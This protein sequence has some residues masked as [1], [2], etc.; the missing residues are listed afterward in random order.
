[1]RMQP[2]GPLP[3]PAGGQVRLEPGGLHI[4]L[5]GLHQDLTTDS[6]FVLTLTFER[7]GTLNLRVPVRSA[8]SSPRA[9]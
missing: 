4:M 7:A 2:T 8:N 3:V 6:E 5:I 1:M 9:H